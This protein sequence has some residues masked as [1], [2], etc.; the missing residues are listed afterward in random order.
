MYDAVPEAQWKNQRDY[1]GADWVVDCNYF[2]LG[3][4][5]WEE[6]AGKVSLLDLLI[7]ECGRNVSFG[8]AVFT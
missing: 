1:A 8:D 5:E 7:F 6:W 3:T 4:P 2:G